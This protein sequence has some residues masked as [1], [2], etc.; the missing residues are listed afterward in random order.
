[1]TGLKTARRAWWLALVGLALSLCRVGA[2]KDRAVGEYQVK[3]AFLYNF[4][5]FADWPA[6]AFESANAPFVIGIAGDDPFGE[7][8]DD[9]VR[10]ESVRGHPLVVKRFRADDDFTGCHLLFISR[11]TKDRLDAVLK[12]VRSRPILTISDTGGFAE[13]G[14]MVNLLLVQGSVKME[15]NRQ[16][17]EQTG[18]QI[19]SKLLSLAQIVETGAAPSR[20]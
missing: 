4:T 16:A 18:L 13:R 3:A 9:V 7:D 19:S 12:Q 1:M 8:L 6:I 11:S 17:A 10:N 14:V 5:K 15:I 20:R 2:G